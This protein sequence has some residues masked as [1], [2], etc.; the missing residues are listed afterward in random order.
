[1]E[2]DSTTPPASLAIDMDGRGKVFAGGRM[3]SRSTWRPTIS[4][5]TS[6]LVIAA[7][8]NV[9]ATRP[10]RRTVARLVISRTSSMS[11]E[12]KMTLAPSATISRMSLN[13]ASTSCAGRNGVGS[14]STRRPRARPEALER[15]ISLNARTIASCAR[16][17]GVSREVGDK[18][19]SRRSYRSNSSRARLASARQ[20]M[21]QR[22]S[23][24]RSSKRK[25]SSTVRDGSSPRC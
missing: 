11:C 7:V 12:T 10:S 21:S 16:S 23:A 22:S 5:M 8:S 15:L 17:T 13:N 4:R 9:P 6:A 1:M 19:S 14:S 18:G 24:A 25:F 2:N 20:S 3:A